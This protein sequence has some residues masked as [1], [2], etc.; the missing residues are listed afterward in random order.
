MLV[1][2]KKPIYLTGR[3][4]IAAW[5]AFPLILGVGISRIRKLYSLLIV[6]VAILF[7]SSISLYWYHFVWVKSSDRTIARF[8]ESKANEDDLIVFVPAWIDIP[9][10][11]YL[12]MPLKGLGYPWNSMRE[13]PKDIQEEEFPRKPD[14]MVDLARSKLGGSPGKVFFIYQ[15]SVTWVADMQVVKK[16][17]DESFKKIE[18]KKYGDIEV[19]I[20]K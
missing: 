17:F 11:Y 8:I 20:Y 13:P 14:V 9:I 12:R 4:S 16:L 6:L 10:N 18:T 2:I 19:T 3:Y 7:V 15:E 5:P 1:S